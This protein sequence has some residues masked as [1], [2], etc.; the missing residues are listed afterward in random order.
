MRVSK[1]KYENWKN[2]RYRDK[3][4]SYLRKFMKNLGLIKNKKNSVKINFLES[5]K[6]LSNIRVIFK[7][8]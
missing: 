4:K 2:N 3:A 6:N 8:I 5:N 7:V 1:K